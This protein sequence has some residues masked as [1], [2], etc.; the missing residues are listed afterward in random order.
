MALATG[1]RWL[2]ARITTFLNPM[3]LMA[4]ILS[5]H[6]PVRQCTLV[7]PGQEK[8]PRIIPAGPLIDDLRRADGD[9]WDWVTNFA[10]RR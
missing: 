2:I 5:I 6:G 3:S 9:F 10:E 4:V 1:E 7:E 8:Y